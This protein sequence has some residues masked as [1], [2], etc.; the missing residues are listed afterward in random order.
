MILFFDQ[1][2]GNIIIVK[3]NIERKNLM[4][5]KM[6]NVN[7]CKQKQ[8]C[9]V[10]DSTCFVNHNFNQPIIAWLS[11]SQERAGSCQAAELPTSV[12]RLELRNRSS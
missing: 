5:Y 6:S 12:N 8:F 10:S 11:I 2:P 9:I 3:K 1:G 4:I 7:A